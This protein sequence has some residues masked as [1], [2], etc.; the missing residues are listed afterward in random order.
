[1]AARGGVLSLGVP[2]SGQ[3]REIAMEAG[4]IGRAVR[5]EGD[6]DLLSIDC[7]ATL[8][9]WTADAASEALP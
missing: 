5:R 4:R 3:L 2:V 9:G 8:D 1:M 7:G 6:G